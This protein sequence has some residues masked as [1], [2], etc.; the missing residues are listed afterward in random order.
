MSLCV[1]GKS[2]PYPLTSVLW[3]NYNSSS[4]SLGY[5]RSQ[6][7]PL[8]HIPD[9]QWMGVGRKIL[10]KH[11]AMLPDPECSSRAISLAPVLFEAGTHCVAQ[12]SQELT[13][14]LYWDY[15]YEIPHSTL[16]PRL[17]NSLAPSLDPALIV[18]FFR[19]LCEMRFLRKPFQILPE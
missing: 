10:G 11:W 1:L 2:H 9:P 14:L 16:T 19:Y 4:P 5:S 12:T 13:I 3:L 8:S 17:Y 7:L 6:A 15:K 18:F